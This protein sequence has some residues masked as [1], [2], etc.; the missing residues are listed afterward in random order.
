MWRK[1]CKEKRKAGAID[2]VV[3]YLPPTNGRVAMLKGLIHGRG[4]IRSIV[5]PGPIAGMRCRELEVE[6]EGD[7]TQGWTFYEYS[8]K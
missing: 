5:Y 7:E 8:R 4:A 6:P 1:I 3:V 2:L